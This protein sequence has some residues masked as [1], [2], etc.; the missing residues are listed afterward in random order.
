MQDQLLKQ[1]QA[2]YQAFQSQLPA[3]ILAHQGQFALMRDEHIVEF[4]DT[5]RDAYVMG[6]R[7]F[8]QDQIF[9]VQEVIDTPVD[10]GF[11]SCALP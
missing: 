10:L 2:N 11:F 3:L 1:I 8:P 7:L 5:A 4:F 9:S 6:Q